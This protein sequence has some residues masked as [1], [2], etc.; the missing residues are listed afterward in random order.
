M[1]HYFEILSNVFTF[2]LSENVDLKVKDNNKTSFLWNVRMKRK[3]TVL[4]GGLDLDLD[5]L[6]PN[7]PS[8]VKQIGLGN[9]I[10][11]ETKFK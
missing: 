5:E 9:D 8:G 11:L 7:A 2:N 4:Q 6:L 1:N 10:K 3:V